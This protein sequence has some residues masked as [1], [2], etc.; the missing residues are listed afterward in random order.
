Q[1]AAPCKML[2]QKISN[3]RNFF[4]MTRRQALAATAFGAVTLMATPSLLRVLA[5]PALPPPPPSGPFKLTPLPYP[6]DA[7]EPHIDAQ[8]MQIHHDRHH[9]TYVSNLN[10]AVADQP[11]LAKKSVEELV[12]DL[13][14][15]PEKIRTA[16]RNHGG[17]HLN[18]SLVWQMLKK[19]NG[20]KAA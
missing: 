7:L 16:V 2:L 18:H 10:K 15:V 11:D 5:Q 20:S 9:G 12:R 14:S 4:M 8:T 1:R 6:F 17:G 3:E 13:A 19:N